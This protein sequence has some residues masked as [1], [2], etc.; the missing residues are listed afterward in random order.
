MAD[1]AKVSEWKNAANICYEGFTLT[2][3]P[4][5]N[6]LDVAND[7]TSAKKSNSQAVA[8]GNNKHVEVLKQ[9]N[10]HH[11][12]IYKK[13]VLNGHG[14]A[15]ACPCSARAALQ[16]P[17]QA[18]VANNL[19]LRF[20]SWGVQASCASGAPISTAST[21]SFS[22]C[23]SAALISRAPLQTLVLAS[24]PLH[25]LRTGPTGLRG[26]GARHLPSPWWSRRTRRPGT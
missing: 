24:F 11:Q 10:V 6:A 13:N 5:A 20:G 9:D 25:P 2:Q 23:T 26:Q 21:G 18:H 22:K 19:T 8:G 1:G 7:C 16:G 12:P 4:T 14:E 15:C 17:L 3:T